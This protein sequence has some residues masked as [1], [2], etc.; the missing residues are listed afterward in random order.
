MLRVKESAMAER[1]TGTVKW[2]NTDKGFGYISLADGTDVFVHYSAINEP[3]IRS[4]VEGE[5]VQLE[6]VEG[7]DGPRAFAVT[8]ARIKP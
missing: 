3:G 8:R 7:K 2:F 1:V 5:V 4:L 6:V